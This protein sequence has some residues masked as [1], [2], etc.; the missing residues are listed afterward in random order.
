MSIRKSAGENHKAAPGL[1]WSMVGLAGTMLPLHSPEKI[2]S[3]AP[4]PMHSANVQT[5]VAPWVHKD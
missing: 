3:G 4:G 2:S 1:V 5:A